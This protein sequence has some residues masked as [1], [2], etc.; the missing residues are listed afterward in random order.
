MD[1]GWSPEYANL[2]VAVES[3][4]KEAAVSGLGINR[5]VHG[6]GLQGLLADPKENYSKVLASAPQVIRDQG[7][8]VG[9]VN[10]ANA[11]ANR[12][13]YLTKSLSTAPGMEFHHEQAN[14]AVVDSSKT[15]PLEALLDFHT[16]LGERGIHTGA[17]FD[18]GKVITA[19]GHRLG[20]KSAHVDPYTKG[21]NPKYWSTV[22]LNLPTKAFL[23][24]SHQYV[25]AVVDAYVKQ[26]GKQQQKLA[27]DV[28][29]KEAPIREQL[30]ILAPSANYKS[31]SLRKK[32]LLEQGITADVI[33]DLAKTVHGSTSASESR[34]TGR[35]SP[36][37]TTSFW[38]I[39]RPDAN[40]AVQK[41]L[42]M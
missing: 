26:K 30:E 40:L 6:R 17:N 8:L 5:E 33:M 22:P 1:G 11:L 4:I 19:W 39:G 36:I 23:G 34:I 7:R 16:G 37:H 3:L 20:A 32:A 42:R 28:W 14:A 31:N 9:A 21:S 27:M 35:R 2:A 41:M 12:E 38:N 24:N 15:L 29:L 18:S 13:S 10:L 25:E